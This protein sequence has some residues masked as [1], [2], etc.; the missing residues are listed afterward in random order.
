MTRRVLDAFASTPIKAERRSKICCNTWAASGTAA[1]GGVRA[2][3]VATGARASLSAVGA[4]PG[5]LATGAVA[6]RV[7]GDA[8]E[9][10]RTSHDTSAA[11]PTSTMANA[12]I[13]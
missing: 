10:G 4:G 6:I 2:W 12:P 7:T 13:A 1:G 3:T 11:P 8:T 5:A 9:G